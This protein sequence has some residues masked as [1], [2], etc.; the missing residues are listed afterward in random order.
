MEWIGF[1]LGVALLVVTFASVLDALVVPRGSPAR[2][3]LTVTRG[4]GVVV[5]GL[6]R[7]FRSYEARD[8][9]LVLHGP[10]SLL[11]VL[12]AWLGLLVLAF[13]L[14]AW[15]LGEPHGLAESI[16]FSGSSL[17]TLGFAPASGPGPT[18]V[19]FLAAGSGM[20]V[21]ALQIAYLPT[22]Y[23][24]FN[25]RETLVTLL[26]SRAGV[27]AWGPELLW[28]HQRVG[29]FDSLPA[30]YA[31]WETWAADVAETHATYPVLVYFRSPHPLRSWVT[32]LLAVLDAAALHLALAPSTAP[33][34]ARLCLRMGF[35]SVRDLARVLGIPHDGDPAPDAPLALTAAEFVEAV[36]VLRDIGFPAE[37]SAE[38]AWADFRG[39]R[40]N[41]ESV[42]HALGD[43]VT[44]PPALWSGPRRLVNEA[45]MPVRRPVDRRPDGAGNP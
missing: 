13:G 17:F 7:L 43:L 31:Q 11:L 34:E 23:G 37:R 14:L 5:R 12:I 3:A 30:L 40:V 20:V 35:T 28:R 15:P 27:P 16:R 42:V 26:E 45:P 29:I 21:I 18:T 39:W 8:R 33:S 38:A 10:L 9:V 25:R 44:A 19:A 6:A 1:G 36:E 24:A 22:I 41:Y 4:A 32:S 2:F